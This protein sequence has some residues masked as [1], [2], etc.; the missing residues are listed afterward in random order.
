MNQHMNPTH[1]G[2]VRG[3]LT[4]SGLT[5]ALGIVTMLIDIANAPEICTT[6]GHCITGDPNVRGL[7]LIAFGFIGMISVI[8]ADRRIR[9]LL[10][11]Q[12]EEDDEPATP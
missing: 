8:V 2:I 1:P 3:L 4:F 6:Y 11:A 10:I 12:Y 7:F 5:L 9:D